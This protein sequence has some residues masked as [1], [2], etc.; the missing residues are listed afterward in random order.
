MEYNTPELVALSP[1]ITAI[2]GGTKLT[3]ASPDSPPPEEKEVIGAY[4][5]WE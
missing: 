1:A 5:D 4:E 3:K 2:Q